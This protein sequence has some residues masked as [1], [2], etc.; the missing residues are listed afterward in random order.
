[1]LY[2][3]FLGIFFFIFAYFI[4]LQKLLFFQKFHQEL[5]L[6]F[7][8]FFIV[9][10][11]L[12][13][14]KKWKFVKKINFLSCFLSFVFASFLAKM[15]LSIHSSHFGH[16]LRSLQTPGFTA[17]RLR[18]AGMEGRMKLR[19]PGLS[20]WRNRGLLSVKTRFLELEIFFRSLVAG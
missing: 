19:I 2:Q 18:N 6:D 14:H 4:T 5:T 7:N 11:K 20:G 8:Y 9:T 17:T 15:D 12:S 10:Q 16:I 13:F 1:M 3:D